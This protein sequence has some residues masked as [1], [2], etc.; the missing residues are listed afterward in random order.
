MWILYYGHN[1]PEVQV[2]KHL[3]IDRMRQAGVSK[4]ELFPGYREK[5]SLAVNLLISAVAISQ[6]VATSVV[7][8]TSCKWTGLL[9]RKTPVRSDKV[10]EPA[11]V[12]GSVFAH[13]I[14]YF[15]QNVF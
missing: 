8:A 10:E 1:S 5:R 11:A 4:K 3:F 2:F 15:C 12:S 7:L 14:L 9:I 6:E 13:C